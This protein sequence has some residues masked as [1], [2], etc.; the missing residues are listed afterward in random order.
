MT[1]SPVF[2]FPLPVC[3]VLFNIFPPAFLRE[4]FWLEYKPILTN[5]L[6]RGLLLKRPQFLGTNQCGAS[7]IA[8]PIDKTSRKPSRLPYSV[9]VGRFIFDPAVSSR[10]RSIAKR[11]RRIVTDSCCKC[12]RCA[13]LVRQG[14]K[15][16]TPDSL[17]FW[18]CRALPRL[19][20]K[21]SKI[22]LRTPPPRYSWEM[23]AKIVFAGQRYDGFDE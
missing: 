16:A 5:S 21:T 23:M 14:G 22:R 20:R 4:L 9:H 15:M 12:G 7:D 10:L 13:S 1:S 8:S 6:G 2:S 11:L 17:L 19:A 3:D 18:K